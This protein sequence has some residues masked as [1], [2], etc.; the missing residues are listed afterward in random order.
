MAVVAPSPVW[1]QGCDVHSPMSCQNT[2]QFVNAGGYKEVSKFLGNAPGVSAK[3]KAS[4]DMERVLDGPPLDRVDLPGNLYLFSACQ[5]H[6][7]DE[8][9][10]VVTGRDGS[11]IATGILHYP[12]YPAPTLTLFIRDQQDRALVEPALTNWAQSQLDAIHALVNEP[13]QA[14][15]D[16]EFRTIGAKH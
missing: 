16:I 14:I 9:G 8:K 5:A 10:A 3:A 2:N 11:I 1:S 7:C 4:Q 6:N 15:T 12:K 13:K